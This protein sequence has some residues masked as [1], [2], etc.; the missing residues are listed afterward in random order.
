MELQVLLKG[1][2]RTIGHKGLAGVE[3]VALTCCPDSGGL[4]VIRRAWCSSVGGG[5]FYE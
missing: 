1:M 2:A 4:R 5:F 3:V